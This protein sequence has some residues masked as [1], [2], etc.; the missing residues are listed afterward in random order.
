M[1]STLDEL[2]SELAELS[3]FVA[4]IAPVNEALS[5][6]GEAVV[7]HFVSLRRRFDNAAFAVA[8][9]ASFEKFVETLAASYAILE[10]SRVAYAELPQRLVDKHLQRSADLLARGRLGEGRHANLHAVDVVENLFRCLK[11]FDPYAL[12][13][14][15][16]V[17]HDA[18]LRAR[19]VDTLFADVGIE[20]AC[21]R[22]RLGDALIAWYVA[23]QGLAAAPADGVAHTV[24]D[25]RLNALVER[26]NQ[27]AHRGGNPDNLLGVDDMNEAIGFIDGLSTSLFAT[28]VGRYL[29]T[30]YG[31]AGVS[32]RLTQMPGVGPFR[33]GTVVV[34]ESPAAQLFVGQPVFVSS[35][36]RGARWGRIQSLQ[37]DDVSVDV[38]AAGAPALQGVGVGLD[39]QCQRGVSLIVL[40]VEDDLVWSPQVV[41]AAPE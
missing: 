2:K 14:A 30:R 5:G 12:N 28:V 40:A 22:A 8:V 39:F 9:Y 37:L 7:R 19:D 26:R 6:H 32:T 3:A 35:D 17:W 34:V 16:V 36:V 21:G 38:V 1:R 33:N 24:I 20:Q 11:G 4:S 10:A 27:I 31:G 13:E 41:A 25:E 15:A 29:A 23:L 18:N